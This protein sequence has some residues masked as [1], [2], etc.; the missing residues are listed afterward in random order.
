MLSARTGKTKIFIFFIKKTSY[1]HKIKICNFARE[2]QIIDFW[3]KYMIE[4]DLFGNFIYDKPEI[5]VSGY[6]IYDAEQRRRTVRND[7]PELYPDLPDM[8]YDIIYADPP[9]L[10]R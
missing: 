6:R 8:K 10:Y 4:S 2:F 1:V 5:S 7:L 9:S 3:S